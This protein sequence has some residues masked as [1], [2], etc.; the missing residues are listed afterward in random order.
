M[1]TSTSARL[2]PFLSGHEGFVSRAYLD[3]GGILTIGYGFTMRSAIFAEYWR[4]TRGHALRRGDTI[5]REEADILLGKLL[6]GEYAP[7]VDRRFPDSIAQ[8]QFD[9]AT[10]VFY[11]CGAGAGKWQWAA[12]LAAGKV[13]SAAAKLRVT[14]V[15]ASGRRLQGLVNRRADEAR[16]IEFGDYGKTPGKK[17]NGNDA[18]ISDT[19]AELAPVWRQLFTLGH[20]DLD[21]DATVTTIKAWQRAHKLV[22]DGSVGKASLE[23]A[24]KRAQ[25][26]LGL[27]VD[28][29][30]GPATRAAL[31]RAVEAKATVK[32]GSASALAGGAGG[33]AT[34]PLVP[35]EATPAHVPVLEIPDAVLWAAAGVLIMIVVVFIGLK[36]WQN[37]GRILGRRT[38]A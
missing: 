1:V 16:L 13:A 22:A 6:A 7:P 25:A 9:G 35:P 4:R 2:T 32:I 24:V 14:A 21:P 31:I 8:H 12:Y 15:T 26:A 20:I 3:A 11:N 5:T 28:G 10:S 17:A 38:P 30:V 34:T 36:L 19:P 29:I 18:A 33:A 37:R 23:A 27:K